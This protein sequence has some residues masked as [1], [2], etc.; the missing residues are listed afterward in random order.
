MAYLS[1]LPDRTLLKPSEVAVFLNVSPQTVHFWH[2][3]GM[4]EPLIPR[5]HP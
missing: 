5:R 3:M 1:E 2:P 4:I